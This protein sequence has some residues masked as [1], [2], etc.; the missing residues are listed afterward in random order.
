MPHYRQTIGGRYYKDL[1][2]GN[3][4]RVSEEEY[5]KNVRRVR[6]GFKVD[7]DPVKGAS[8]SIINGYRKL[9]GNNN[10]PI[11]RNGIQI[12]TKTGNDQYV[13]NDNTMT[14]IPNNNK[15]KP[16]I[17]LP[18]N[19]ATGAPSTT[20][21]A[22]SAAG[23]GGVQ[24]NVA[25]AGGGGSVNSTATTAINITKNKAIKNIDFIISG[26]RSAINTNAYKKKV[27]A[28]AN[29]LKT[30]ISSGTMNSTSINAA[31]KKF[32][33]DYPAFECVCSKKNIK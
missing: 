10:N 7:T 3:S 33:Q 28:A 2:N 4:V 31:V 17:A 27:L 8:G 13:L 23:A 30:N 29:K 16:V 22:N 25:G 12:Y 15:V 20:T 21:R 26:T 1:K 14:P 11:S 18:A 32:Q 6:G 24:G 9:L 5:N 19:L